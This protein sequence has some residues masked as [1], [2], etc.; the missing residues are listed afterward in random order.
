MEYMLLFVAALVGLIFFFGRSKVPFSA[1]EVS[2]ISDQ[3]LEAFEVAP[4]LWV[5]MP[6]FALYQAL[7][8]TLPSGYSVHGKVRL[9]DIIRVKRHVNPKLRW[10][11]RGRV[12]SRHVDYLIIDRHGHPMMAIELDG[13]S[14]NTRNPSEADKVKTAL[15][16]AVSLPLHRI[17]VGED[18]RR[19][20]AAILSELKDS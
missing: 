19:I 8:E 12:K 10:S 4:S 7:L 15:F 5:N 9:E 20:T 16:A 6:E 18:F 1:P 13:S 3:A 17:R 2:P 14:H 11:L